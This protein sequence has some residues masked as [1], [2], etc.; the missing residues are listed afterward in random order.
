MDNSSQ[1]LNTLTSGSNGGSSTSQVLSGIQSQMGLLLWV[2]TIASIIVTI[3]FVVY[4]IYKMRVQ[5]AI[6]RMD[7]NLQRLVDYQVPKTDKVA[8]KVVEKVPTIDNEDP[9]N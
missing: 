6:L 2:G 5:S 9:E 1:L 4:L 7:K 3:M 8:E